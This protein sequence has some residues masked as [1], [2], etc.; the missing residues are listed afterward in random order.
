VGISL[1]GTFPSESSRSD[2]ST[3][4]SLPCRL[5]KIRC[6]TSWRFCTD[7]DLCYNF[8]RLSVRYFYSEDNLWSLLELH[9]PKENF[10]RFGAI[11]RWL[12]HLFRYLGSYA[13]SKSLIN[14][15]RHLAPRLSP[16]TRKMPS[17]I[18]VPSSAPY[19]AMVPRA[20]SR[21]ATRGWQGGSASG[22]SIRR[23]TQDDTPSVPPPP[24]LL[25]QTRLQASY[26]TGGPPGVGAAAWYQAQKTQIQTPS[27]NFVSSG[28]LDL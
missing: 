24:E 1:G 15:T 13:Q 6:K 25:P 7:P 8:L 16:E 17:K 10:N 4:P 18:P 9:S 11:P 21:E 19:P 27:P 14:S 22:D 26:V 2:S 23:H 20:G 12:L 5:G 28:G 3:R